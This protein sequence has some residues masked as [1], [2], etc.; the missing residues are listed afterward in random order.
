MPNFEAYSGDMRFV[1]SVARNQGCEFV[2][3]KSRKRNLDEGVMK[4]GNYFSEK[5][6]TTLP[7]QFNWKKGEHLHLRKPVSTDERK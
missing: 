3:R 5:K 4:D 6:M 2:K 7:M 1:Q